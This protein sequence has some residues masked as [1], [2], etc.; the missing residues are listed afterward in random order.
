MGLQSRLIRYRP[1]RRAAV[2]I[3]LTATILLAGAVGGAAA[4]VAGVRAERH[5]RQAA[6]VFGQLQAQLEAGQASAARRTLSRLRTETGAAR[7][8]TGGLAWRAGGGL[9][10]LGD[11]VRAVGTVA[12]TLDDLVRDG[13]T[14]LVR[15]AGSLDPAALAPRGGRVP[16][17]AL[18]QAEPLLRA[19]DAAVR[20]AHG[21]VSGIPSGGLRPGVRAAVG[22]LR[23]R[24]GRAASVTGTAARTAA[25][26]PAMLGAD[27]PRTYLMFFQNLAEVR[28][29]GGLPGA[30]VIVRADRGTVRLLEQGTAATD[31]KTFPRPVLPLGRAMRALYTDRLATFPGDV[32]FTPHFPTAAALLREMY[33]RRSGRIVDGVLATDPVA[34]SYLLR[35]TGPVAVPGGPALTART[36]VR[37]LL[38][39]A[40]A[41]AQSNAAQDR[42]FADAARAVFDMLTHRPGDPRALIAALARAAGERRLLVWTAH[43]AEQRTVAG[44]VLEGALPTTDGDRPTVGVFLN[45][46]GGS[47]LSY[48]LTHAAELTES[49]CRRAGRRELR[50]RVRLGT[51]APAAGLPDSVLGLGLAGRYTTRTNVVVFAPAGGAVGSATVDGT[52]RPLGTGTERGRA[53]GVVTLDLR[54]GSAKTVEMTLLT[55]ADA[56]SGRPRLWTTPGT[57][58][59]AITVKTPR[60]CTPQR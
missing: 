41:R 7:A 16:L 23:D 32:N 54:P 2:A 43:P 6:V 28:A 44:T 55:S 24:L 35:V 12:A 1:S 9:P 11:D 21:R 30:Y 58:P 20:R 40:Y 22:Q 31:M 36:A 33:R 17:S 27:G 37:Q 3:G 60:R 57:K 15:A 4:G 29:T 49:P 50:L 59:W 13:L 26:L 18:G 25:A 46:G 14:P 34:L 8:A 5:L 51:T 48:Y 45:D 39:D 52:A 56:S 19:A 47:K 10:W 38:A 42:Y 53:V